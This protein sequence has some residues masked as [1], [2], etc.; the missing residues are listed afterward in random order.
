M[1]LKETSVYFVTFYKFVWYIACPESVKQECIKSVFFYFISVFFSWRLS[2]RYTNDIGLSETS[3]II[4]ETICCHNPE[5][6][7]F[8]FL[9]GWNVTPVDR[10]A[11][12]S[13]L[14]NLCL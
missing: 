9:Y 10:T 2:G 6:D 14:Y 5:D 3:L 4:Y 8:N 11:I 13:L 12:T 7:S 1:G